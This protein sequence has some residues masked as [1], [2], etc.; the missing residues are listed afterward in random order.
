MYPI[1][2]GFIV[3]TDGT[4]KN[5]FIAPEWDRLKYNYEI[6]WSIPT[7][8]MI[9]HYAIFQKFADQGISA[10]YYHDFTVSTDKSLTT[11]KLFSDWLLRVKLG[12]KTKYYTNSKTQDKE[13]EQDSGCGSG[14]C[15]I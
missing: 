6:A 12:V 15:S 10:D 2:Q 13:T 5:F 14:G 9:E 4:N 11:S 3:K 1:R 8:D 7:K